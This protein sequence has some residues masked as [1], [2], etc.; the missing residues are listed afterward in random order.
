MSV[1]VGSA[2]QD[3]RGRY[4]GGAAGDQTG[5]EVA[6]QTWYLH[7]KGWIIL[8]AKDI[9]V[10]K[11]IAY[12]MKAACNNRKIGYDQSNRSG[13]YNA[14]KGK[15]FDPAKCTVLTETDCSALVRVCVCYALGKSIPDFNTS[16]EV[17]TLMKTGAFEKFTDDAHCK[18]SSK[19]MNG[20][21]LVTKTKGHTVVVISG[22]I[23]SD[24]TSTVSKPSISSNTSSS[25]SL[26]RVGSK[27]EAVKTLQRNLNSLGYNLSVDGDFGPGT[28]NAVIDFQRKNGLSADG[29]VGP[30][31]QAKIKEK[32]STNKV[33]KIATP[34]LRKGSKGD[35]VKTLQ[36]NLKNAIN[37]NISVDGDFGSGTENAL[38]D[39]QRRYNLSVDGIYGNNSYNKMK[40]VLS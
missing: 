24:G 20:D 5:R 26:L 27:G 36:Q 25:S 22:G 4:S 29:I 32:L 23:A 19:L 14:V 8:R 11:K 2:R 15:G 17:N 30:A 18:S 3:E 13:L 16:S 7:S 10:R 33:V 39:F 31:T 9:N 28:K 12:A 1:Y 38:K 6:Y 37:A 35:N 34:T 21:I 40:S